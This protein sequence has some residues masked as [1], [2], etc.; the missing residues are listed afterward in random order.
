[1]VKKIRRRRI[2]YIPAMRFRR[3]RIRIPK[4]RRR[5]RRIRPRSIV[6]QEIY[7]IENVDF[8][9]TDDPLDDFI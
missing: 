3:R 8:M 9:T 4:K 7:D 1:M 5:I 2:A 6:E